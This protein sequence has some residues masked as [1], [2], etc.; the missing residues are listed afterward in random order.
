MMDK[1]GG[2][3]IIAT[4]IIMLT[5][6]IALIYSPR[7]MEEPPISGRTELLESVFKGILISEI[8]N[9][10]RKAFEY[11]K[12]YVEN[13]ETGSLENVEKSLKENNFLGD[14]KLGGNLIK[15][16]YG[17][18]IKEFCEEKIEYHIEENRIQDR[19]LVSLTY[20]N[21]TLKY[22][23]T[24]P[25]LGRLKRSRSY[26]MNLSKISIKELGM[27][28][29]TILHKLDIEFNLED[30]NG[31]AKYVKYMVYVLNKTNLEE[32]IYGVAESDDGHYELSVLIRPEYFIEKKEFGIMLM[33]S[34]NRGETLWA[35]IKVN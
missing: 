18:T 8:A 31:K 25:I 12:E 28:S 2:S 17:I 33:V 11:F 24:D 14:K 30:S 6:I 26:Y 27:A 13:P 20:L 29:G 5:I 19:N 22:D 1:R 23:L 15:S 3:Y 16:I 7:F 10:T 21:L 4:M 35:V 9:R 32:V 34:G